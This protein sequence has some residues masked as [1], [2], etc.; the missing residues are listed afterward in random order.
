MAIRDRAR[1]RCSIGLPRGAEAAPRQRSPE[2]RLKVVHVYVTGT[3]EAGVDAFKA[4]LA[5]EKFHEH[6]TTYSI[7]VTNIVLGNVSFSF[8]DPAPMPAP[9]AKQLERWNSP[10]LVVFVVDATDANRFAE[11]RRGLSR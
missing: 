10:E 3:D 5:G 8:N 2:K 9:D 1:A 11:A 7:N 4:Y 6:D